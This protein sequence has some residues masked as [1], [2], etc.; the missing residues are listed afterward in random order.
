MAGI[1]RVGR[2]FV[3]GVAG[4]GRGVMAGAPGVSPFP[5]VRRHVLGGRDVLVGVTASDPA[6]RVG[7]LGQVLA[8]LFDLW[9]STGAQ[10]WSVVGKVSII[11]DH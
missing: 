4:V 6:R 11:V 5:G 10:A 9:N 7:S 2:R 3:A 8:P 1:A